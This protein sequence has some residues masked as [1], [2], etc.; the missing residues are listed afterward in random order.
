M[1]ISG[2]KHC[3]TVRTGLEY[4]SIKVDDALLQSTR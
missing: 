4:T 3:P 1:A 2:S